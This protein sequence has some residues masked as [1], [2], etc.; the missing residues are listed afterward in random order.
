MLDSAGAVTWG[1]W[2]QH[3][4]LLASSCR[5]RHGFH[6][7][8]GLH[9]RSPVSCSWAEFTYLQWVFMTASCPLR[10]VCALPESCLEKETQMTANHRAGM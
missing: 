5:H 2:L 9:S 6:I 7:N 8:Q 4:L 3:A 1:G 10:Q